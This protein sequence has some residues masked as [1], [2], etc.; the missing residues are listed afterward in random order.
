LQIYC[1]SQHS[2]R[3]IYGILTC[4]L[5][6]EQSHQTAFLVPFLFFIQDPLDNLVAL[7]HI[8][9]SLLVNLI[10]LHLLSG[11]F[12]FFIFTLESL[13]DDPDFVDV[14][15]DPLETLVAFQERVEFIGIVNMGISLPFDVETLMD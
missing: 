14:I 5:A 2:T 8:L 10:L 9:D 4:P 1:I 3:T 13:V 11:G 15:L 7:V 6:K 12:V